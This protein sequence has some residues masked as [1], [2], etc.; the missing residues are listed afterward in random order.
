[1]VKSVTQGGIGL[2]ELWDMPE[3]HQ[4]LAEQKWDFVVLQEQSYWAMN[5]E[6]VLNTYKMVRGWDAE[7]KKTG[8]RTL[9]FTTWPRKPASNWYTNEDSAFLRNPEFMLNKFTLHTNALAEKIGA[10]AI[11]AGGYWGYVN[12][13]H[14]EIDLYTNDGSHPG[15]AGSYLNALLFYRYFAQYPL[16]NVTYVPPGVSADTAKILRAVVQ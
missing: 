6:S 12:N 1:M 14:P 10:V 2:K 15:P 8:A 9:L 7:I 16:G 13:A 4:A 5:T 11:P 3:T